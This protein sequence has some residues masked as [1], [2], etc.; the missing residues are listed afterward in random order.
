VNIRDLELF[1]T[2]LLGVLWLMEVQAV[3]DGDN[4]GIH[5]VTD[6]VPVASLPYLT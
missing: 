2:A 3:D 5:I 6:F 1:E 4:I